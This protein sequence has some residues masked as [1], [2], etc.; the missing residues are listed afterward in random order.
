MLNTFH[1]NEELSST[2]PVIQ[3]LLSPQALMTEVLSDYDIGQPVDCKLL[4]HNLNDTYLVSTRDRRYILRVSQAPRPGGRTWRSSS[5]ILYELDLLLHLN[6]KE[7]PVSTPLVRKDGTFLRVLQ[8]PEGP[9]PVVLFTYA[10]GDPITPPKQHPALSRLYGCAVAEIH[11]AASDF[12]S[13]HSRFQL[14][15]AFLL[16][17]SLQ[18]I[19]PVL[20]Q[21]A[22]DWNYLLHLAD[23]LKERITSLPAQSL[24][25]GVCHGDAQGGN[26]HLSKEKRLT[27]FDFDVCGQGWRAYDLAVFYWGAALGKSRLGWNDE[28]VE[29]VWRAYLEGYLERRSLSNI[30]LQAI[31]L[32]VAVRHFWFLGLNTANWDYWGWSAVDDRFFDRELA[33]LREWVR[34]RIDPL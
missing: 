21:R 18:T 32:F 10:S 16:D 14:D 20:A 9:R 5:D 27:F 34:Q 13:P 23:T 25:Y 3:S 6:H 33:F 28:Q 31:P 30:D 17:T 2:F 19:Q 1:N 24:D 29:Q 22:N 7:V 8:A 4:S 15:L 12:V 11:T 26:A